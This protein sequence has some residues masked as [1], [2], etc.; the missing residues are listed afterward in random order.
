MLSNR[1]TEI[2]HLEKGRQ[3][4]KGSVQILEQG[5]LRVSLLIEKT[6]SETSRLRQIVVIT[7]IS[8]RIDFETELDWN[9]NRQFLVSLTR[10]KRLSWINI[11]LLIFLT[12]L[13]DLYLTESGVCM[14][15]FDRSGHIRDS[16][17][18]YPETNALQYL[19]GERKV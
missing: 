12:N 3:V 1:D 17:R 16:I 11:P 13:N 15:Y 10:P 4:E 14:E 5:P 7:A 18:H 6:I 8:K 19:M 9:E 2:Y